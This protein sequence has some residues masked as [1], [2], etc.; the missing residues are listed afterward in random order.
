MIRSSAFASYGGTGTSRTFV[1]GLTPTMWIG[2]GFVALGALAA[3][4]IPSRGAPAAVHE[5]EPA[6]EE[7][8]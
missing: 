4:L 7:A 1:G 8:A 2:A 5:L 6:L 3:L